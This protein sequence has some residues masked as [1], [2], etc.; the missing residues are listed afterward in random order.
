MRPRGPSAGSL[1]GG[2]VAILALAG[3][4]G[5]GASEGDGGVEGESVGQANLTLE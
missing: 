1:A 5:P 4:E 3:L 2:A